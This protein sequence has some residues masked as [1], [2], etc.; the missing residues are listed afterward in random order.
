M[1]YKLH[2]SFM[3]F[4]RLIFVIVF[5]KRIWWPFRLISLLFWNHLYSEFVSQK[6]MIF[7]PEVRS[8]WNY[9][10][11]F[12]SIFSVHMCPKKPLLCTIQHWSWGKN[13]R[14]KRQ[15]ITKA[16]PRIKQQIVD[17]DLV[18]TSVILALKKKTESLLRYV[19][20]N[21]FSFLSWDVLEG[22]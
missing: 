17:Y 19:I 6:K 13:W 22:T 5:Q 11:H 9:A 7:F 14:K 15:I 1:N 16:S 21:L 8:L 20:W 10:A 12:M 4:Q 3:I 18:I 2:C